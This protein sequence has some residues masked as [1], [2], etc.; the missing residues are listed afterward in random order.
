[1]IEIGI[2]LLFAAAAF[3]VVAGA[4]GIV[5]TPGLDLFPLVGVSGA[6]FIL[7]AG[8]LLM[9]AGHTRRAIARHP[10][11]R[12]TLRTARLAAVALLLATLLALGLPLVPGPFNLVRVAG[13]PGGY[14]IAAQGA[15]IGLAILAFWWAARQSRIDTGER[16]S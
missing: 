2:G 12:K 4:F 9:A 11:R 5:L 8:V 14:Y 16:R 13:F 10:E 6:A 7:A 3:V 1:M 15:L